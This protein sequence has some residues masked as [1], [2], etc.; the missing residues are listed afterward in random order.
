MAI[1]FQKKEI[2][3]KAKSTPK[4]E[5]EELSTRIEEIQKKLKK[6][7]D[8]QER[9]KIIKEEI[10]SYLEEFQK[11]PSFAAPKKVRDEAKEIAKF[12]K[13]QQVGALIALVFE[14]GLKEAISVAQALHNPAI[15]DEFHDTLV[16]RFYK[17][18]LEKK[19][20]KPT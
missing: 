17:I 11:L 1:N 3:E 16:D 18:L 13:E 15:L 14:K 7:G 4:E 12:P 20:I 19:I 8:F 9:E 10:K 5:I 2:F 6:E